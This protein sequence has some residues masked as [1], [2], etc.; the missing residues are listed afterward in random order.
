LRFKRTSDVILEVNRQDEANEKNQNKV[1]KEGVDYF[2][3]MVCPVKY[4]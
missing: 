2:A 4:N 1:V 3:S